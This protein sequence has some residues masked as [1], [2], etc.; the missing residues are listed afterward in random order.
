MRSDDLQRRHCLCFERAAGAAERG[1]SVLRSSVAG[2]TGAGMQHRRVAGIAMQHQRGYR[3][4]YAAP[5]RT[6]VFLCSVAGVFDVTMHCRRSFCCCYA[7]SPESPVFLCSIAGVV[8]AA[9]HRR[10]SRRCFYAA[11]PESPVLLCIIVRYEMRKT[12]WVCHELVIERLRAPNR[13]AWRAA[14][15]SSKSAG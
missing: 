3:C 14:Y 6:P 4:L 9:M 8:A 13:M 2:G 1:S 10:R 7:S 5:P 11:S 15:L 12:S